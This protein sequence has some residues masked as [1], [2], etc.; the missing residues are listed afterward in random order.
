MA[1]RH[2][3]YGERRIVGWSHCVAATA[4]SGAAHGGITYIE[5]CRCGAER[6]IES[7]GRHEAKGS[8]LDPADPCTKE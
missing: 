4:C 8:W 5:H 3:N 6:R 2:R 1:H 7:N